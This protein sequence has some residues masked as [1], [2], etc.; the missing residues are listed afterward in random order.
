MKVYVDIQLCL[1]VLVVTFFKL[2]IPV[3]SRAIDYGKTIYARIKPLHSVA[4][5]HALCMIARSQ[6]VI[7]RIHYISPWTLNLV[8][9][10]IY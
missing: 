6:H 4:T 5:G 7:L 8:T 3:Y 1:L 9:F 10:K 2:Y